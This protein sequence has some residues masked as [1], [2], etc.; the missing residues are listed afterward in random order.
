MVPKKRNSTIIFIMPFLL[1]ACGCLSLEGLDDYS[2]EMKI[3]VKINENIEDFKYYIHIPI[4]SKLEYS[5]AS[6]SN[7]FQIEDSFG[8]IGFIQRSESSFMNLSSIGSYTFHFKKSFDDASQLQVFK[9]KM[10]SLNESYTPEGVNNT[11]DEKKRTIFVYYNSNE[12]DMNI[13]FELHINIK[14]AP[15]LEYEI[16]GILENGWN[17]LDVYSLYAASD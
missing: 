4:Y 17:E 15:F 8:S 9:E 14:D 13:S 3:T 6:F 10:P 7:L 11:Y 2:Y 5:N 1:I 12:V 16:S